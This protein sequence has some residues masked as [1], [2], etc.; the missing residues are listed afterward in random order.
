MVSRPSQASISQTRSK[1]E[2]VLAFE[3][4][5][6][7]LLLLEYFHSIKDL[8]TQRTIMKS[9]FIVSERMVPTPCPKHYEVVRAVS[10]AWWWLVR[11]GLLVPRPEVSRDACDSYDFS[12]HAISLKNRELMKEYLDRLQY[13]K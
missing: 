6:L 7:A 9:S 1:P 10:E 4:Q 2:D 8:N 13:P 12:R 5:D 11:E 3:P